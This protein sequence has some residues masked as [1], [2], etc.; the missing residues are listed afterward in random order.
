MQTEFGKI[1]GLLESVETGKTPLQKNLDRL[2]KTLA[3]AALVVVL[4]ISGAGIL[5]GQP[6]IDMILF[7]IALA[8][9]VVPEALPAVVTI[10]LA[11]GVQRMAKRNALI[12]RLPAVE[13]LGSTSVICTDKTGTLTKDEMT[14]RKIVTLHQTFDVT[15][16]GYD[17][18]GSFLI[19]GHEKEPSDALR[20][21]LVAAALSSDATLIK[22]S[23]GWDISGDPTEG[24][25]V[26]VAAKAGLQ[27]DTLVAEHPRIAEI[28]FSSETKRMTTLHK[29]NGDSIAFSKGAPEIIL[30]H[31][32]MPPAER[33]HML[34][35]A[36]AMAES[37]LRVLAIASKAG[38]TLQDAE[39]GMAFW[40]SLG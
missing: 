12:R 20:I 25:L 11:I 17:P 9:A 3:K 29:K 38:A 30:S 7:G 13:T 32:A 1:A 36:H 31:C 37:S 24:A 27:R 14:V 16:S 5:R 8:V 39:H 2:G 34:D 23:E 10:S 28:P 33:E 21:L 4:F 19:N 40:G 18:Q 35:V 15:G 6:V 22:S 26:T